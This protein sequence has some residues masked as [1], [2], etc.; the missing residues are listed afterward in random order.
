MNAR[1]RRPAVALI[2]T[3]LAAGALGFMPAAQAA[4]TT[5]SGTVTGSDT[6]A[7]LPGVEVEIFEYNATDMY[8]EPVD[9]TETDA[10]GDYAISLPD[11]AYR[12]G[13]ADYSGGHIAE[14]YADVTD[15]DDGT[16]VP[17]SSASPAV[18]DAVL[19]PG[20]HIAGTVTRPGGTELGQV[21]VT[22]YE[23]VEE[24]G[25]TYYDWVGSSYTLPDG[26]YDIGGLATG[27]YAVEFSDPDYNYDQV[28]T[29]ATEWYDDVTTSAE[30][31]RVAVTAPE[32]SDPVNAQLA[33]DAEFSGKIIDANG[34]GVEG[35]VEAYTQ[36][37]GEWEYVETEWAET[38]GTYVFDGLRP[39]TY[40]VHFYGWVD[41]KFADEYWNDKGRIDDAQ[42]ITVTAGTPFPNIN[43]TLVAGEHDGDYAVQ[44]LTAP[45]ISG[46]PQVGSP[47]TSS[48]GTWSPN[49]SLVEYYWVAGD[50]LLQEGT[51][52]TYVPTAADLGKIISVYV[53]ASAEDL[54]Y[55]YAYAETSAP[56]IAAAPVVTPPVVTPPV[57]TP[58][59]P[60][61]DV[62]A[63]L[64][65]VLE[66]VDTSG[67]PKVGKTIK[68]TGLDALF[69]ASTAVSYKFKWYAGKK[70]IK[71]ATKSKLKVTKAMKGKK[72]SVKVT[73]TAASTSKSVKLKVGK[74]S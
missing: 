69:R 17:V 1:L 12:L 74:V 51:S 7:G 45:V 36:V 64:A 44:N 40:R 30:A 3:T 56:V 8:W 32:T 14:Y 65:A 68:V 29:W 27:D 11:G 63:G 48:P 66:G 6:D 5:L 25:E 38:D 52:P 72:L 33:A 43:A 49:P 73:A 55:G 9:Y 67:K 41:G 47:L 24:D 23:P 54:D 10:D 4:T 31:D 28:T 2:T 39:G 53:Y 21:L 34:D 19:D 70:A 35:A 42:D 62:P 50:E 16:T 22:V 58:P 20:A 13:F 57:V 60:V 71:K 26:S 15:V 37:A 61:V 59:A 18:V 46:T